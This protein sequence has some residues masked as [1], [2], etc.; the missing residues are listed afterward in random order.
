[1]SQIVPVVNTKT[2]TKLKEKIRLLKNFKGIFQI[3]IADGKFTSWKTWNAPQKLKKIKKIERKFELHLMIQNPEHFIPFWL[4]TKPRR[5]I[6]HEETIQDWKKIKSYFQENNTEL[7][8]AIKPFTSL[9]KLDPYL[10]QIKFVTFLSVSPGPSG[11]KFKWFVLDKIKEFKTKHPAVLIEIDGGIKE[12]NI[13]EVKK[14]GV[15]FIAMGSSI[16]GYPH[17]EERIK[18]WQKKVE[19][20]NL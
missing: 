20:I 14:S 13:E 9:E 8:L 6:I 15:D 4:E 1:M 11:Q 12:D 16:F 19:E 2:T 7:A 10:E 18:Y 3:D 17:P 5:I